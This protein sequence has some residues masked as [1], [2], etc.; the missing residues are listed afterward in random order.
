MNIGYIFSLNPRVRNRT[1][2]SEEVEVRAEN[3][4]EHDMFFISLSLAWGPGDT[5]ELCISLQFCFILQLLTNLLPLCSSVL[6][7]P[8]PLLTEII[9]VPLPTETLRVRKLSFI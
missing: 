5:A 2:H 4:Q 8:F 6:K 9:C 3:H 1:E 7:W